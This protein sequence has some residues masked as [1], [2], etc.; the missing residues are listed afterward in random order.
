MNRDFSGFQPRPG[1]RQLVKF[2]FFKV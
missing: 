2:T 1:Q